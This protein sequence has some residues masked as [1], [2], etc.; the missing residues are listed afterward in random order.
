MTVRS[1][2]AHMSRRTRPASPIPSGS[3]NR[4]AWHRRW[5]RKHWFAIT[6]TVAASA[7][8]LW[9][10][11]RWAFVGT[12]VGILAV[13]ALPAWARAAGP[14]VETIRYWLTWRRDPERAD[15]MLSSYAFTRR[16]RRTFEAAC[17]R[18]HVATVPRLL[19]AKP[20]PY[21]WQALIKT[22]DHVGG[23]KWAENGERIAASLRARSVSIDRAET[24]DKAWMAVWVRDP[25]K[26]VP[27][28]PYPT[29]RRLSVFQ[30]VVAGVDWNGSTLAIP[31]AE[32]GGQHYSTFIAGMQGS[33]KTTLERVIALH[34]VLCVDARLVV[35]DPKGVDFPMFEPYV[36]G[37]AVEPSEV[38]RV[39]RDEHR[40]MR[41][42]YDELR[43]GARTHLEISPSSPATVI[44]VDE[45]AELSDE[46]QQRILTM[47]RLGRA[48]GYSVIGAVQRPTKDF[49]GES[50]VKAL[51]HQRIVLAT[52]SS[53]ESRYARGDDSAGWVNT[54]GFAKGRCWARLGAE[55]WRIGQVLPVDPALVPVL[56]ARTRGEGTGPDT[57]LPQVRSDVPAL[58]SPPSLPAV[59]PPVMSADTVT[60]GPPPPPAR[61][62]GWARFRPSAQRVYAHLAAAPGP[63][64]KAS[65]ERDRVASKKTATEALDEL[66]AAGLVHHTGDGW[67]VTGH[68]PKE[69]R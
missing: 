46:N 11:F 21:G 45:L 69:P 55:T 10:R 33:G 2:T 28:S 39:L 68:P 40:R 32:R 24:A 7:V 19:V 8:A 5:A 66:A 48:A 13:V 58:P 18:A 65:L 36:D 29:A 41:G 67:T 15:S 3:R 34:V 53:D 35:I 12:C 14:L 38:D 22:A 60:S 16:C 54:V 25:F 49:L 42:V 44:V 59:P 51:M 52:S 43:S 47:Q 30:P 64:S 50:G 62:S 57:P 1:Y 26:K 56:L 31:L 27:A 9:L 63:V 20:R 37:F 6:V 61:W 23:K 4:K 17:L